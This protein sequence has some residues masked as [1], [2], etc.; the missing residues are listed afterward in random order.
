MKRLLVI[1]ALILLLAPVFAD[2]SSH[3]FETEVHSV[4]TEHCWI[5]DMGL[6][7]NAGVGNCQTETYWDYFE[8]D[9]HRWICISSR[10][11]NE[12]TIKLPIQVIH[13]PNCPC[14][15]RRDQW[16][17]NIYEGVNKLYN[18]VKT[19]LK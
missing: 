14:Q 13:D 1:T 6:C 12:N 4:K 15:K 2:D 7:G 11:S 8:K 9:G 18:F 16:M 5:H 10:Y 17:Q 3:V 19:K